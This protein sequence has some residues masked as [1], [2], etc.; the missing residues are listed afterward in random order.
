MKITKIDELRPLAGFIMHP[1]HFKILSKMNRK[2]YWFDSVRSLCILFEIHHPIRNTHC[3]HTT[4]YR[5]WKKL[6]AKKFFHC[7]WLTLRYKDIRNEKNIE[8]Q[9]KFFFKRCLIF[10]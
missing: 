6:Q 4:K 2:F 7:Q 8:R 10:I 1:Y 9:A 3:E 5:L